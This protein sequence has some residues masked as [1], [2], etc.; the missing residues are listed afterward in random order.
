MSTVKL[1]PFHELVRTYGSIANA[2]EYL[3]SVGYSPLD[4]HK[5]TGVPIHLI[6]MLQHGC[7]LDN[8]VMFK[9]IV[10]IYEQVS[11][12]KSVKGKKTE[13]MKLLKLKMPYHKKIRF[14]TG[15]IVD[16][17]TGVS[18]ETILEA[19]RIA[20]N[21]SQMKMEQLSR[22]YGEVGEIAYL[23]SEDIKSSLFADE[24]YYTIRLLPK[25]GRHMKILCI[26]SLFKKAGKCESKYLARLINKK[27]YLGIPSASIVDVISKYVKTPST[28]LLQAVQIQGLTQTLLIAKNRQLLQKLQIHPLKFVQPQLATI[29]QV[30]RIEYPVW[31]EP[32]YDGSRV[33]IHK[34]NNTIKIYSRRG[35]DKTHSYPEIVD[36]ARQFKSNSCII[37]AEV[38]GIQDDRIVPFQELLHRTGKSSVDDI[39]SEDITLS[40]KAFDVLYHQQSLLTLS[41]ENRLQILHSIVPTQYLVQG[42]RC[43]SLTE[44]MEYY[45]SLINMG[46]EGIM[47]K[48]LSS[49]YYPN[50]R[51]RSW[52]KLK[53]TRDSIDA[54]IVKAKYGHGDLSGMYASFRLAIRHDTKKKLYEI[55]DVGGISRNALEQLYHLLEP[56]VIKRDK[57]GARVKPQ[58]VVEVCFQEILKSKRYSSGY[59]LRNPKLLRLRLDKSVDDIDTIS[60][61]KQMYESK[62]INGV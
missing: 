10:D 33:Q 54:V 15:D 19:L 9:Q 26:A 24:V 53:P 44:V 62:Q 4:I 7:E 5:R 38:V 40:I 59:A 18:D 30:D 55:G 57:E 1:P 42:K 11:S 3:L 21:Q 47:V 16:E 29:L 20:H 17:A 48:T 27:L 6:V 34:L 8:R 14:I 36:I 51:H 45:D 39:T 25:L 31:C 37:D 28:L 13:L 49:K 58:I 43:D 22:N 61:I 32:K 23:L 52:M 46:Y 56:L 60:K 35:I 50:R 2:I 12:M 41:L